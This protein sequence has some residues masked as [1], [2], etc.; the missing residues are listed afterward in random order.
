M[1]VSC[2]NGGGKTAEGEHEEEQEQSADDITLTSAQLKAVDIK[3][4][5]I[6][7]RNLNNV[8]RVNGRTALNAQ[9]QAEVTSLAGGIIRQVTVNEGNKVQKGQTV[10][11][12]ENTDIVALQRDYLTSRS[13]MIA[14]EQE[15]SRQKELSS[16]GAGVQKALQQAT[17][18][19]HMAKAKMLGVEKQLVQLGISPAAVKAGNLVTR[20]PVKAPITGFVDKIKVATGG[21]VDMQTPIM[22][23]VDNSK[24]HCDLSIF[25]KDIADVRTGQTVDLLLTNR[26]DVRFKGT[27]YEIS[28]S[29]EGD[30][31]SVK[32]HASITDKPE[33]LKLIP[34]MYLTAL[35]HTGKHETS[36]LPSDAIVSSEGK[37][38]IFMLTKKEADKDGETY[39]FSRQE[40]TT[41]I[42]ELGYTQVTPIKPLPDGATV[43]TNNA[44]YLSSILGGGEEE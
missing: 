38:Y 27:V 33:G 10:A 6:E 26:P 44:F 9:Y 13:A 41:G 5:K 37:K 30:T 3:L 7:Q 39:H 11:Y 28:S 21:Y 36:A 14:A 2:T 23:I 12:I 18:E 19:C 24:L 43:V 31:K 34:D 35:I 29:F 20:I 25:E 1:A 4:G 16:A 40:V 32:A 42:T 15:H 8:I 17:A 22:Y